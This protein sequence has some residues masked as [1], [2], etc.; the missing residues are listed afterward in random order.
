MFMLLEDR[1]Q[2]MQYGN[3]EG[4]IDETTNV[5]K[6]RRVPISTAVLYHPCYFSE[7]AQ[8]ITNNLS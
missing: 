4:K 8:P 1:E 7:R 6:L 2:I 5:K 3:L